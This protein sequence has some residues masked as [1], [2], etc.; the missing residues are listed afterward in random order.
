MCTAPSRD[1]PCPPRPKATQGGPTLTQCF[2]WFFLCNVAACSPALSKH[3]RAD[4]GMEKKQHLP[5][6]GPAE[7]LGHSGGIVPQCLCADMTSPSSPTLRQCLSRSIIP[8]LP[9]TLPSSQSQRKG[10][11]TQRMKGACSY[12]SIFILTFQQS[13]LF[14]ILF[15]ETAVVFGIV[16]SRWKSVQQGNEF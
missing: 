4:K 14:F 12:I 2:L 11:N 10:G 15:L 5:H 13:N 8:E 9:K 1:Q 6:G 16:A 7:R 3:A